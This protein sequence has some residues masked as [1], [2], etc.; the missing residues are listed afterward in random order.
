MVI[1]EA[2]YFSVD[3]DEDAALPGNRTNA[4]LLRGSN[5]NMIRSFNNLG[6]IKEKLLLDR[7]QHLIY[8][9]RHTV[10]EQNLLL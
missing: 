3:A 2:D 7:L 6:Q 4:Q 5:D 8:Y 9:D 10:E 1:D